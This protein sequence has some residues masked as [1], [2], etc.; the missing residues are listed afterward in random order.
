M[1]RI[2]E[3]IEGKYE[4]LKEVGRGGMSVVYL[5]M[6][7]RLNKQWAV[8]EI[9]RKGTNSE[10]QIVVQSLLSE[11][12]L[13]K[14]LDHPNLPRIVDI[15]ENGQ[16]I[17]IVMDYIEGEPLDKI[18][19][20]KGAQ[21]EAA[22]IEWGIQLAEV[23]DYL[24]TRK[25]PIIYRD[26]KPANVML[27]P[28]GNIKLYDFG[29]AR[30]YKEQNSSD[31]VSLGTKGYAAPEQFGGMGQTDARTDVYGLGVTLYHLVTGK[32]PCEPPYEILPIRDVNPQLSVGL[33][34]IIQKCTQ[35]NPDERFQSCM[36]VLYALNH[37]DELGEPYRKKQKSKLNKFI[38][39]SAFT[40]IMAL[41]GT[42][43]LIGYR[44]TLNQTISD[45]ICV[46]GAE[47]SNGG[48]LDKLYEAIDK[49]GIAPGNKSLNELVTNYL[50]VFEENILS[51]SGD[52]LKKVNDGTLTE[53]EKEKYN[54][55]ENEMFNQ[56]DKIINE[57]DV[58]KLDEE[59]RNDIYFR[60]GDLYM[61]YYM[62]SEGKMDDNVIKSR[63]EE[64][65]LRY[66][67]VTDNYDKK[68]V[69][70]K[71]RICEI[72]KV[73]KAFKK[74]SSGLSDN[75]SSITEEDLVK[76][77]NEM[78]KAIDEED[79]YM[80]KVNLYLIVGD[81]VYEQRTQYST[82]SDNDVRNQIE[83][84][85]IDAYGYLK[86]DANKKNVDSSS[87]E[88]INEKR[89]KAETYFSNIYQQI[90]KKTMEDK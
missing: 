34:Y 50:D 24:H 28:D 45:T 23:L 18:L 2:G 55:T 71:N 12:N 59:Y 64:A 39:T 48:N 3:V 20:K 57:S 14:R 41:A 76:Y 32:N 27:K 29:I 61:D 66:K 87:E 62:F 54:Q 4:I 10:N 83:E 21:P 90:A 11:A 52:C 33:E 70:F 16:T 84:Y 86:N 75:G 44:T 53:Q 56:L 19:K 67:K 30:E 80:R 65:A 72:S 1:S 40:L 78:V 26:M 37:L 9:K 8:K 51:L 88:S 17:Y 22:V 60:A 79:S 42:G 49:Y 69:Q 35:L 25:P 6:D 46:Y 38:L 73:I 85:C 7:N 74:S 5:A 13:M 77:W 63:N 89:V 81:I 58:E 36:E 82:I 43:T 15:I 47:S 31:T 68:N